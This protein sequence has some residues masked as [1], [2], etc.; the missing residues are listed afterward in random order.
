M[1]K[2]NI[3]MILSCLQDYRC[4]DDFFYKV[5]FN[6]IVGGF[7]IE[8]TSAGYRVE[9]CVVP[10]YL[11]LDRLTLDYSY[12]IDGDDG[13]IEDGRDISTIFCKIAKRHESAIV[14][15]TDVANFCSSIER[16]IPD[17]LPLT[18][19]NRD[20]NVRWLSLRYCYAQSLAMMG[21]YTRSLNEVDLIINCFDYYYPLR[22][23]D[24][25]ASGVSVSDYHLKFINDVMN[26]K[27][28][29][30]SG[31]AAKDFLVERSKANIIK[32]NL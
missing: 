24:A 29:L 13:L 14:Y 15:L 16:D 23:G 20:A 31:D 11:N 21:N 7:S 8:R 4:Q 25:R 32:L 5:P 30:L 10:L 22:K 2:K 28:L 26:L 17:E 6:F 12:E 9:K 27:L 19:E 3:K 18:N 1:N